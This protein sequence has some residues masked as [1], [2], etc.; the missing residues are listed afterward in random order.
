MALKGHAHSLN[1]TRF[2]SECNSWSCAK[3]E[4]LWNKAVNAGLQVK[5]VADAVKEC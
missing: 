2:W 4:R 5:E 1:L 3:M